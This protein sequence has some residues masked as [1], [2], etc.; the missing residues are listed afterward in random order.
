M[1]DS[2][3]NLDPAPAPALRPQTAGQRAELVFAAAVIELEDHAA[4]LGYTLTYCGL[5]DQRTGI[6]RASD[7][8]ARRAVRRMLRV[9]MEVVK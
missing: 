3:I 2:Y 7:T 9:R 8:P 4:T 1:E 6:L 5:R